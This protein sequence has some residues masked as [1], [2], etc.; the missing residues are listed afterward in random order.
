MGKNY[1]IIRNL[2]KI[3]KSDVTD[4]IIAL[5]DIS[6]SINKGDFVS[7]VGSNAAGKSTLFNLIMGNIYPSCGDIILDG[8]SI[9]SLPEYKRAKIISCV[10]QNPNESV[11][12]SMTIAE[13]MALIM[14]KKCNT[15]LRKGV[16]NEWR[17]NFISLLKSFN[18]GLE[19][20]LDEKINNLSGGQKQTISLLMATLTE[21]K[22][23]LL[24]EHT[25]ALDPKVSHS[26]LEITN[27]IVNKNEV[28]TLMITHNIYQALKYGNRLIIFDQGK[29][30]LDING[31]KKKS[32]D[33]DKISSFFG[34][35]MN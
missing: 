34:N 17:Y 16:K 2:T 25:A 22:L 7:I 6:F 18:I 24:D 26:V 1:L 33:I 29:I 11:I 28:T 3:Y 30:V 35:N 12:N 9:C 10:K 31:M 32:F 14:L 27:D 15:G 4:G 20:K 5:D 21:P 13:N 19:K 8:Q 23:L